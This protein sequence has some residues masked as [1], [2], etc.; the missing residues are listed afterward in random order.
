LV[1]TSMGS[2]GTPMDAASNMF[3]YRRGRGYR[4]Y[5]SFQTAATRRQGP[6]AI[7]Q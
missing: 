2:R 4:V 5:R 6:V 1:C 3:T 7:R